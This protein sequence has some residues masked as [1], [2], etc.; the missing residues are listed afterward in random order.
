[1]CFVPRAPWWSAN[2]YF[3]FLTILTCHR[4]PWLAPICRDPHK[5]WRHSSLYL[6][7]SLDWSCTSCG[8]WSWW[9]QEYCPDKRNTNREHDYGQSTHIHSEC[10]HGDSKGNT[11]NITHQNENYWNSKHSEFITKKTSQCQSSSGNTS[12]VQQGYFKRDG[13]QQKL[14][15][16]LVKSVQALE[17]LHVTQDSLGR[18]PEILN[19]FACAAGVRNPVGFD[20]LQDTDGFH[21]ETHTGGRALHTLHHSDVLAKGTKTTG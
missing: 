14:K 20:T 21:H 2:S 17:K 19:L 15:T 8:W 1:M 13:Q 10:E 18:A 16:H 3:Y 11:T 12:N 6:G 5:Q 9:A 4:L 7:Q